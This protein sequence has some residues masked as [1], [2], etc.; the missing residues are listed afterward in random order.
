MALLTAILADHTGSSPDSSYWLSRTALPSPPARAGD[1][2][3]STSRW[4]SFSIEERLVVAM[5]GAV[6]LVPGLKQLGNDMTREGIRT[7]ADLCGALR[8][9]AREHRDGGDHPRPARL[10]QGCARRLLPE[11]ARRDPGRAMLPA[12]DDPA[13]LAVGSGIRR[14]RQRHA[15]DGATSTGSPS[16]APAASADL[17]LADLTGGWAWAS[18][19]GRSGCQH[20]S[21]LT[22]GHPGLPASSPQGRASPVTASAGPTRRATTST[23]SSSTRARSTVSKRFAGRPIKALVTSLRSDPEVARSSLSA[24]NP[25]A[26]PEIAGS[27]GSTPTT[28]PSGATGHNRAEPLHG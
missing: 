3:Y 25:I 24:R 18:T 8:R 7:A 23:A 9:R 10:P 16:R 11:A 12:R 21:S 27:G 20:S 22:G 19:S 5:A 13:P 6:D 1:L 28:R 15:P 17:V 26:L 14:R 4:A 2:S